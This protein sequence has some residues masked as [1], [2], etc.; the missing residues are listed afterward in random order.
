MMDY[1]T[2]S[3]V[4]KIITGLFAI[5]ILFQCSLIQPTP[6]PTK[7]KMEGVWKVTAAYDTSGNSILEKI[8]FPII[9]FQLKSDNGVIST[10]GPMFTYIVYGGSNYVN[11]ANKIDQVF[12]YTNLDFTTDGEWFIGTGEVSRFTIEM[13]LKG[14]PGATTLENILSDVGVPQKY[15][16]IL[17]QSID[18]TLY[19]KFQNVKVTFDSS[20]D[21]LMT[22]EFDESTVGVYNTKDVNGNYV[23]WLGWP[24]QSFTRCKFIL[25]K[26][27]SGLNDLIR[28]AK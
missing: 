1:S 20:G 9:G 13:R 6:T 8:Q 28:A 10:S 11:V 12:N 24:T 27:A 21:S 2:R 15:I 26:K 14:L 23:L 22:W 16:D 5:S 3:S 19:H 7:T 18:R 25:A 17:D 4:V